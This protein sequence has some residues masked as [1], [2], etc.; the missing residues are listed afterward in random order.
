MPNHRFWDFEQGTTDLGD[1]KAGLTDV[2][3]LVIMDFML[4]HGNDWFV[5]PIDIATG[6][7]AQIRDLVVRDVFGQDVPIPAIGAAEQPSTERWTMFTTTRRDSGAVAPYLVLPPSVGSARPSGI[8]LEEVRFLRDDTANMAWAIEA[9]TTGALGDL[10]LAD[11]SAK[12]DDTPASPPTAGLRY[13]VRTDVP[14]HWIPL[15]PVS[16]D[17]LRGQIE[18]ERGAMLDDDGNPIEPRGRILSPTTLGS[19]PY[20]IREEEV[21]RTGVRIERQLCRSRWI[22]GSTHLWVQRVRK[23]GRGEGRSGLAFDITEGR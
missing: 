4:V 15:L 16:V 14:A 1:L 21:P 7:V 2:A 20:R 22:D 23:P 11:A 3:R 18:L 19:A 17:A 12:P 10:V 8:T 13:R 6:S 5:L 9:S